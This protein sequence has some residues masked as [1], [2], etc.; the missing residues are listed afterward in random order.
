MVICK[1][2]K[3]VIC[4]EKKNENKYNGIESLETKKSLEGSVRTTKYI[5]LKKAFHKS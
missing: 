4:K 3:K 1:E 2:K 5:L